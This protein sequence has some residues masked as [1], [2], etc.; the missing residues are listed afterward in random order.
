MWFRVSR[1][2]LSLPLPSFRHR[3]P[4]AQEPYYHFCIFQHCMELG[5]QNTST[6]IPPGN[7]SLDDGRTG[8]CFS[9][10]TPTS[11]S[12]SPTRLCSRA[13]TSWCLRLL[14]LVQLLGGRAFFPGSTG[15]ARTGGVGQG[16][17]LSRW[18]VQPHL[19]GSGKRHWAHS[20]RSGLAQPPKLLIDF[21]KL[22]AAQ[23][24]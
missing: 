10:P 23:H 12:L 13:I 8:Q 5:T 19:L 9:S 18:A 3:V 4:S 6:P 1:T 15:Q 21:G 17:H 24:P 14:L 16:G 22:G 11:T 20:S 7:S 2:A